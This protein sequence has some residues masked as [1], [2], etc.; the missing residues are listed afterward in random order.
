MIVRW[1]IRETRLL[2][3]MVLA[4]RTKLIPPANIMLYAIAGLVRAAP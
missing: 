2:V 3:R 1:H 4:D